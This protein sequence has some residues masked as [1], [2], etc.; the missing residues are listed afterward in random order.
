MNGITVDAKVHPEGGKKLLHPAS[1]LK[2]E[3]QR[4]PA[5]GRVRVTCACV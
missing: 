1:V 4:L 3:Q 2:R 5:P